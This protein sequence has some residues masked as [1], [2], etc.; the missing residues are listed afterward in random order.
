[1]IT[2]DQ[3]R[4]A[5]AL[6]RWSAMDLAGQSGIGI[7]TIKRLELQ[8]GVPNVQA[9]TLQAIQ[10]ALEGAGIQFIGSPDDSPG[11]RLS[12]ISKSRRKS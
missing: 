11:V 5:R 6:L 7:S 2:S 10:S 1:M 8:A 4:A 12:T 9:K 3:I